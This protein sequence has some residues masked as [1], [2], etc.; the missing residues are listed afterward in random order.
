MSLE[1]RKVDFKVD[2]KIPLTVIC[3]F[4]WLYFIIIYINTH[5]KEYYGCN[6][7]F[8]IFLSF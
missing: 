5:L 6:I 1:N 4:Y 3:V 2:F 7:Y 8:L